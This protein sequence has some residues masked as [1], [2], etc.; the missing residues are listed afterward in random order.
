MDIGPTYE[1]SPFII[2]GY[3]RSGTSLLAGIL[4]CCG[5]NIGQSLL[6]GNASNKKGH[7]EETHILRFQ[8]TLL[9]NICGSD[10]GIEKV[11]SM[12]AIDRG[13][14]RAVAAD[15]IGAAFPLLLSAEKSERAAAPWGW[16]DPRTGYFIHK[17]IDMFPH[18]R[19]ICVV[20]DPS[21]V[22]ESLRERDGWSSSVV[23]DSWTYFHNT[24][25][26]YMDSQ[27]SIVFR[28]DSI[29]SDPMIVP[30]TLNALSMTNDFLGFQCNLANV[31]EPIKKLCDNN[32]HHHKGRRFNLP[33]PTEKTFN[34]IH[35]K[36]R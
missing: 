30:K 29:V 6:P 5:V 17:W 34:L 22:C 21:C 36:A 31:E 2:L 13:F 33:K 4:K 35:A 14:D 25:L 28:Y 20:R 11:P 15:A 24:L 16:K 27:K 3:H 12:L 1:E 19:L 32:L 26:T 9:Q 8:R 7:F 10:G 18:A 23:L